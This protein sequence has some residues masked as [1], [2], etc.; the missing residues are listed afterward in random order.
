MNNQ[1]QTMDVVYVN[2]GGVMIN[3]NSPSPIRFYS[4]EEK[5]KIDDMEK[6][7]KKKYLVLFAG[8]VNDSEEIQFKLW[9]FADGRQKAYDLI[10]EIF[11]SEEYQEQGVTFD[12][13]ESRIIVESDSGKVKLKGVSVYAFMKKMKIEN[14]IE[15]HNLDFDI[16]EWVIDMEKEE[17]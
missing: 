4:E 2:G 7:N 5:K 13:C 1:E 6:A 12:A 10:E 8:Y 3:E 15:E 14:L 9:E 11:L 16:E 17:D